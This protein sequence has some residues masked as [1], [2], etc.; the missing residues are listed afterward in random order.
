M[1]QAIPL[2]KTPNVAS[3]LPDA[4]DLDLRY[5]KAPDQNGTDGTDG[6]DGAKQSRR[7]ETR[8]EKNERAYG[9]SDRGPRRRRRRKKSPR[10]S[11]GLPS[12]TNP[13]EKEKVNPKAFGAAF[14]PGVRRFV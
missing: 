5:K 6:T 9:N 11:Q 3:S 12:S 8:P 10:V 13:S 7:D 4:P 14:Y 1:R 2:K